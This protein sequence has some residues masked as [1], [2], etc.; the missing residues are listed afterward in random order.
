MKFSP[1][2]DEEARVMPA[3]ATRSAEYAPGRQTIVAIVRSEAVTTVSQLQI[4]AG[5][6]PIRSLSPYSLN[7]Q[8]EPAYHPRA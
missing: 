2:A 7:P 3:V 6:R 5:T 1:V 8:Q 4:Q